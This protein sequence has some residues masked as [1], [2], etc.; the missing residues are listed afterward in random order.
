MSYVISF[1]NFS[2]NYLQ[3]REKFSIFAVSKI[4]NWIAMKVTIIKKK[5]K[6]ETITR[7][8]VE[9]ITLFIQ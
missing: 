3:K 9:D 5:G 1:W 6:K 4:N 2:V 8:P 7:H